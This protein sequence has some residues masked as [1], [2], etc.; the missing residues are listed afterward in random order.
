VDLGLDGHRRPLPCVQIVILLDTNAV[1]CL[2]QGHPR[3]RAM[4][5][6]WRLAA[7]DDDLIAQLGPGTTIEL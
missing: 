7:G 1:I 4:L 6:R 3:A 2:E 5:R